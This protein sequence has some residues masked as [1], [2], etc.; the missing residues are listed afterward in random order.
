MHCHGFVKRKGTKA[1]RK[2]ASDFENVKADFLARIKNNVIEH[3]IPADMVVN[4]E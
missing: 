3:K 4:W 1:A 2:L